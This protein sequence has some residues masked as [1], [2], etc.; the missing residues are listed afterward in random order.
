MYLFK[1]DGPCT[2]CTAPA[3]ECEGYILT[4]ATAS[5]ALKEFLRLAKSQLDQSKQKL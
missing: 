1:E 2:K 3:H 5:L 4:D